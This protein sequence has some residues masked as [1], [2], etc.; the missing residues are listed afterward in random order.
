MSSLNLSFGIND[1][2]DFV[3]VGVVLK[4]VVAE[5]LAKWAR[6][7]FILI[8]R[9]FRHVVVRSEHDLITWL[10][11]EKRAAKKGHKQRTPLAC[12]DGDC[13]KITH[14]TRKASRSGASAYTNQ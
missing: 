13:R 8:F 5:W 10:H 7:L 11:F 14:A 2:I 3:V 4:L 6:R 9:L 12:E 1:V